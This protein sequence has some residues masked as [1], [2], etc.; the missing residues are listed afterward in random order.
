MVK[1]KEPQTTVRTLVSFDEITELAINMPGCKC[2]LNYTD[3]SGQK[4][5]VDLKDV[6]N[7]VLETESKGKVPETV[8]NVK[9]KH[10]SIQIKGS[11]K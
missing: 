2:L 6:K 3:N 11:K 5:S 7:L 8:R 9:S 10:G 1:K 4:H